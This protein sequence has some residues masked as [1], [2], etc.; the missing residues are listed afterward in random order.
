MAIDLTR[1]AELLALV[2]KVGPKVCAV[3][4]HSDLVVD[5]AAV[6]GEMGQLLQQ[7]ARKHGFLLVDDRCVTGL[8]VCVRLCR[9][10]L[11]G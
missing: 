6:D 8:C 11:S 4:L 10:P 7:L 9:S 3:K 1:Q 5:A 2:D